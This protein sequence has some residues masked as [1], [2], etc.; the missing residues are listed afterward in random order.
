MPP[1]KIWKREKPK[2]L[3][4]IETTADIKIP[5]DLLDQVI[6]QDNA[7]HKVEL[8]IQ[9]KRNLLLVGPPGIGKSMLAQALAMHLPKPTEEINVVNNP[10]N[11]QRPLIEVVK[12]ITQ[13]RI[14]T[15]QEI[16]T[17]VA[18][19]LGFK[20]SKCAAFSDV[21]EH[22]CPTCGKNKYEKITPKPE[23]KT[24]KFG[25]D[26]RE[27]GVIYQRVKDKVK[28][29]GH[30]PERPVKFGRKDMITLVPLGRKTFI[31]ATGASETEL[32]GDVRHDP[33]G[34][35][36][37]IGTPP[38]TR[39][40]AGA[41][42][43]AH[44]GVLFIDE[45]P[46][47]KFLQ[48]FILTAMQEKKFP[49]VGRNPQSAGASVKVDDV[50]CDFTFVGACNIKDVQ[51]I[52]PPLRSRILGNG[53][54][55][56]LNTTMPDTE[57]NEAYLTQFVA[58]EIVKDKRIPHATKDAVEE[59]LE[60]ARKR[61]SVLDDAR[62]SLTLR[63]RDLGGVV[64]MAGD[65]ATTENAKFIEKKHIKEAIEEAKPIEFQLQERYGS[66]WKGIEKDEIISP[67]YGK[68][69]RSYA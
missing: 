53:Y 65:L 54:E 40:V 41:I 8:A 17:F 5:A 48:N 33:Y 25:S 20:C 9:Q 22:T 32:L 64:R 61:A 50:P 26:G 15:P 1:I 28:V 10:A 44:E 37:E 59:L 47:L 67:E 46:H 7:V 66:V 36:P 23:V 49:I 11:P 29:I 39:V 62:N 21:K 52:L 14:L 43:E 2:P 60:E 35:H 57:E 42:H 56:L 68:M 12:H 51:D 55:I 34:S 24:T 19:Q 58:Q 27:V 18:E 38:Y 13:E 45:L 4:E 3:D 31:H 30:E 63:L 16:P 69:G 6:G